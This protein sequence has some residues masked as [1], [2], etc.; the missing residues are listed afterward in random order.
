MVTAIMGCIA[1]CIVQNLSELILGL[2]RDGRVGSCS[3]LAKLFTNARYYWRL[4]SRFG[5]KVWY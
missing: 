2:R 4:F 3:F 5:C 1:R